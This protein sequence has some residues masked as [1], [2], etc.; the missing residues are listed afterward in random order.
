M[1]VENYVGL[2]SPTYCDDLSL[3]QRH[4]QPH[5]TSSGALPSFII[6]SAQASL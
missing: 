6:A 1:S 3:V 5:L 2:A 4:M